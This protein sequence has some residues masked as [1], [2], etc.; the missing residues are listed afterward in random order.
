M[1]VHVET[2]ERRYTSVRARYMIA[3]DT[4]NAD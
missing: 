1:S 3:I 4:V 2:I